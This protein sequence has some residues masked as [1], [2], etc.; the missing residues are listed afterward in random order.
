MTDT[1]FAD[2]LMLLVN[3]PAQAESLL[4]RLRQATV[5]IG[6]YVN[7]NKNGVHVLNK[8][9]SSAQLTSL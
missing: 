9:P 4:Y 2:D 7:A 6:L 5:S 1:D 3:L 8:K